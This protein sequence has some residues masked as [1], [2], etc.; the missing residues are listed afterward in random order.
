MLH[1]G[2]PTILPVESP[3]HSNIVYSVVD[4]G[5]DGAPHF[6][7]IGG[8]QLTMHVSSHVCEEELTGDK[9]YTKF[10]TRQALLSY[11]RLFISIRSMCMCINTIDFPIMSTTGYTSIS[12]F[13]NDEH[14]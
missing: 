4:G 2:I 5:R 6:L 14:N 9:G 13:G 11:G 10:Q 3:K 12:P 1:H 8:P 7:E